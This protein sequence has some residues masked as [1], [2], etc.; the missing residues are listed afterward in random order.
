M[1]NGALEK[2]VIFGVQEGVLLKRGAW[3]SKI[4]SP[5]ASILPLSPLG[6]PFLTFIGQQY[7]R[8]KLAEVGMRQK[9]SGGRSSVRSS[10]H[11]DECIGVGD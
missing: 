11:L 3:K 5:T 1:G 8:M 4:E 6:M 2:L 9:K 7:F 10:R